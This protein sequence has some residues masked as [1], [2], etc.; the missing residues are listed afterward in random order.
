M[1]I[2]LIFVCLWASVPAGGVGPAI[3]TLYSDFRGP[4]RPVENANLGCNFRVKE[5][6]NLQI[7]AEFT[8]IF[9]PPTCRTQSRVWLRK[10]LLPGTISVTTPTGLAS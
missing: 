7:R 3:G 5:K 4:R 8:N 2:A 6:Y 9:K 10:W 1:R